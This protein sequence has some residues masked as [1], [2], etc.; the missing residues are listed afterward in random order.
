MHNLAKSTKAIV[1]S[2][3][4]AAGVTPIVCTPV[5]MSGFE[6]VTFYAILGA[7][8]ATQL[9]SLKAQASLDN[10]ATDP[11]SDIAGTNTGPALDTDGGKLLLLDIHRPQKRYVQAVVNRATANAV[12][13]S[14][15]AVLSS[16]S[17][18]APTPDATVSAQKVLNSPTAGPA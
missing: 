12:I 17:N 15:V 9:T 18:N 3:G 4:A 7:L 16:A 13:Q 11:Y 10:A 6:N 2:A 8:T 14:V 1:V 5:D